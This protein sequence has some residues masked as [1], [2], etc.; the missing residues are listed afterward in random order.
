MVIPSSRTKLPSSNFAAALAELGAT[1]RAVAALR[2]RTIL[3]TAVAAQAML[4]P[5]AT[6]R[7][8]AEFSAEIGRIPETLTRKAK[9]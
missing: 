1:G 2:Q 9:S 4:A 8:L 7:V 5:T 3:P 6:A